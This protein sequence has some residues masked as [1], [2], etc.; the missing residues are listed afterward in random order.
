MIH[1]L[2]FPEM[3]LSGKYSF[4]WARYNGIP[5]YFD[6][7]QINIKYNSGGFLVKT[8]TMEKAS[9]TNKG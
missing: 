2:D 3:I 6:K 9:S 5:Y 1:W 7:R 4:P 8:H